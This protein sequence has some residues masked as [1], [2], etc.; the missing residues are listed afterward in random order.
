MTTTL[1]DLLCKAAWSEVAFA[2][3]RYYPEDTRELDLERYRVVFEKLAQMVPEATRFRLVI[4]PRAP[5]PDEPWEGELPVDVNCTDGAFCEHQQGESSWCLDFRRW[6]EC[7]GMEVSLAPRIAYMDAG[8][9]AHCLWEMT[10]HGFEEAQGQ[11]A[12]GE[13]ERRRHEPESGWHTREEF[14]KIWDLD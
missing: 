10:W 13:L 6:S 14:R 1:Y 9:V 12:L 7:L 2:L 8:V 3:R 4:G 5:D 11:A